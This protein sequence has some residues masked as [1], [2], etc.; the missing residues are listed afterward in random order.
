[1]PVKSCLDGDGDDRWQQF[2]VGNEAA[3]AE[4]AAA[5]ASPQ[6]SSLLRVT[7]RQKRPKI[8]GGSGTQAAAAAAAAERRGRPQ[9]QTIKARVVIMSIIKT[10]RSL[11]RPKPGGV[12]E[13]GKIF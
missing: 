6:N 8:G 11:A 1:M 5:A 4:A 2:W 3:A 7:D 10:K 13:A 9:D 12:R